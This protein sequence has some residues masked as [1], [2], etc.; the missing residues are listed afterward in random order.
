MNREHEGAST[1]FIVGGTVPVT[2]KAYVERSFERRVFEDLAAGEWVLL[3]GP[4]QHGKSSALVRVCAQL[5]EDGYASAFIDLQ[6]YGGYEDDYPG[7]LSWLSHSVAAEVGEEFLEPPDRARGDLESWLE[8]VLPPRYANVVIAIDEASGVPTPLRERFFSQLRAL[9]NT[10]ARSRPESVSNRAVFVFAG[11]FR[12]ERMIESENSPF[13]VS[14]WFVAEDLTKEECKRLAAVGLG[15]VA[16]EYGCR[17]HAATGGQPYLVQMLLRA[18]QQA[19]ANAREFAFTDAIERIYTGDDRHVPTL[20]R[21]V[22]SDANL[23]AL[24][25]QLAAHPV[26]YNGLDFTHTFA[27]VAGVGA[28]RAGNLAVRNAIYGTA[29]EKLLE[30]PATG[31]EGPPSTSEGSF[32]VLLVTATRVETVAVRDV[33]S[34]GETVHGL[35]N[36]YRDLGKFGDA[37][38]AL[39]RCP[40]TGAGGPGGA[41]LTIRDAIDEIRPSSV[42]LVGIAFGVVPRQQRIGDVLCATRVVDY[43][44]TRVGTGSHG[45]VLASPRGINQP[46]SDRLLARL[47]NAEP[48]FAGR[49][50]FGVMLSG[51]KLIDNVDFRDGLL[52]I[53]ADARGGEMEA[54]GIAAAGSRAKVDWCV[55]KA[56]ADWAD[57]KKRTRKAYRQRVAADRAAQF[58]RLAVDMGGF[59]PVGDGAASS[60]H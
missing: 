40:E 46:T 37:R 44:L 7:F 6:R 34:E 38:V 60:V 49:V 50:E 3:L 17:A 23:E 14:R 22:S 8:R 53:S 12:P 51:S 20:M 16:G 35:R 13:N 29:F 4:R 2:S 11:T 18:V 55:V 33:F 27:V 30:R 10:R 28:V 24:A 9:Y 32:D 41:T 26:P 43:E 21:L 36:T 52:A 58:V 48:D 57:G 56:Y 19:D 59:R 39:V 25:R 45:E 15:S 5:N 1:R 54:L 47:Q 42:I 31:I